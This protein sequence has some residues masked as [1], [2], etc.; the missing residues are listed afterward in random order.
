MK[1]LD[2][3]DGLASGDLLLI[4]KTAYGPDA[5]TAVEL[6]RM[7][8]ELQPARKQKI[9]QAMQALQAPTESRL[10]RTNWR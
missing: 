9:M 3:R 5:D 8:G 10:T 6:G 1:T 2:S 7:D 4:T